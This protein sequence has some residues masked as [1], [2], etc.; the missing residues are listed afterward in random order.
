MASARRS[1]GRSGT[2]AGLM[3]GL[4]V[5]CCHL[6]KAQLLM[7]LRRAPRVPPRSLGPERS[8]A[9]RPDARARSDTTLGRRHVPPW[10]WR[11]SLGYLARTDGQD[12]GRSY[13][14]GEPTPTDAES[15]KPPP[16][17][18]S[19][20]QRE[21]RRW[22][23]LRRKTS[24][25]ES[26]AQTSVNP[27]ARDGAFGVSTTPCVAEQIVNDAFCGRLRRRLR[28]QVQRAPRRQPKARQAP[29]RQTARSVHTR[30]TRWSV[31][32]PLRPHPHYPHRR[33]RTVPGAA[34]L[35]ASFEWRPRL[36]FRTKLA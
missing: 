28:L 5:P 13:R 3:W 18:P 17:R 24:L 21:R 6:S 20:G 30:S 16:L 26:G 31:R 8:V 22:I 10:H 4:A 2:Q 23:M 11:R 27:V 35:R 25:A 15:M 14:A 34:S 9:A 36:H 1:T 32:R 29:L 33:Q 19:R 7:A 12:D